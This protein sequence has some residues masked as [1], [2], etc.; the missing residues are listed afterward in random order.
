M[1]F[2][3]AACKEA[4]VTLGDE[5]LQLIDSLLSYQVN[6]LLSDEELVHS[7]VYTLEDVP[8]SKYSA[9]RL[10]YN[11]KKEEAGVIDFDDMQLY[12][13]MLLVKR[14]EAGHPSIL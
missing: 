5:D 7:Y 11:K 2:I 1:A 12:M 14:K 10:G 3:T 8:L 13:Y 9:I 6:N 4:E